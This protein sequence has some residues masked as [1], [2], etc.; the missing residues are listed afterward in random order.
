MQ[1]SWTDIEMGDDGTFV[2]L[3]IYLCVYFCLLHF[4]ERILIVIFTYFVY[5][6]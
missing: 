2:F 5:L 4:H 3:L 6:L 1:V